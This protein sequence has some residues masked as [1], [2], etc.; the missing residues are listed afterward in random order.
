[1]RA[2]YWSHS[3][4]ANWCRERLRVGE[5]PGAATME[6]WHKYKQDNK[7]LFGYWLTDTVFDKVQD[8]V[9]YPYDAYRAFAS[10][11]NNRFVARPHLMEST[12]KPGEWCEFDTR[13]FDS[14]FNELTKFVEIEKAHMHRLSVTNYKS[15]GSWFRKT[16]PNRE[17]GMAYLDWE[18]S[19]TD[20][21]FQKE[22]AIE[23]KELYIWWNDVRKTRMDPYDLLPDPPERDDDSDWLLLTNTPT[24][25]FDEVHKLQEQYDEEDTKML[26]RLIKIRKGLWT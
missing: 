4:F 18:I 20:S 24:Y 26:I 25:K 6:E 14:A 13:L 16:K 2:N 12:V 11:Y 10:Y 7:H 21:P 17:E 5:M 1:M 22:T 23:I 8:I 15:R 19:L 9:Y 3:A